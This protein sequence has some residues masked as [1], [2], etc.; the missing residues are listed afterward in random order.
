[1]PVQTVAFHFVFGRERFDVRHTMQQPADGTQPW[2]DVA[3]LDVLQHVCANDQVDALA[4]SHVS[5]ITKTPAPNVARG[6]E[7]L[8]HVVAR[9]NACVVDGRPKASQHGKPWRLTTT[10]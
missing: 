4:E 9:I 6:A 2:L 8:E 10:D 3:R 1:M 7:A 5:Q